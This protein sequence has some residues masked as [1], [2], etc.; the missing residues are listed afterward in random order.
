MTCRSARRR[1]QQQ[2]V[3]AV[4]PQSTYFYFPLLNIFMIVIFIEETTSEYEEQPSTEI[5][6]ETSTIGVDKPKIS[7]PVASDTTTETVHDLDSTQPTADRGRD[8][9]NQEENAV[10]DKVDEKECQYSEFGPWSECT[11]SCGGG[12]QIRVRTIQAGAEFAT[13]RRKMRE[14]RMCNTN[15][16]P[17]I[18]EEDSTTVANELTTTT[19]ELATDATTDITGDK[20]MDDD[21]MATTTITGDDY[22]TANLDN[23]ETQTTEQ[24]LP[25]INDNLQALQ[26]PQGRV[27][28]YSCGSLFSKSLEV[29][30]EFNPDDRGQEVECEE[31]EV[32]LMYSWLSGPSY[33]TVR[34]CFQPDSLLLG[35]AEDPILPSASCD[36]VTIDEITFAC[37]CTTDLC[38]GQTGVE[39]TSISPKTATTTTRQPSTSTR[40]TTTTTIQATTTQK[41]V[42]RSN[43]SRVKCHQCGNLFSNKEA[44]DCDT[45]DAATSV[46]DY[47][48][49]GEACLWYSWGVPGSAPSIIRECLAKV[50]L[51][52]PFE[53]PLL[54]T[55][56][57]EVKDISEEPGT[58]TLACLCESDLCN[59]NA[60][61][62]QLQTQSRSD[63]SSVINNNNNNAVAPVTEN[64]KPV[65]DENTRQV[66]EKASTSIPDPKKQIE[67][68]QCGSLFSEDSSSP[69]CDQFSPR[70]PQQKGL[71]PPG[72]VCILYSFRARGAPGEDIREC[73]SRSTLLGDVNNPLSVESTCQPQLLPGNN[74][75]EVTACLCD[76]DMCNIGTNGQF[77]GEQSSIPQQVQKPAFDKSKYST[78][79]T[80]TS[81]PQQIWETPGTTQRSRPRQPQ[82]P[83]KVRT[84]PRKRVRSDPNRVKCHQCGSLYSG[85]FKIF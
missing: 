44:P 51:L 72:D 74:D 10:P 67:C 36:P 50:I 47:C 80:T 57:C 12:M 11:L 33:S 42:I 81:R 13:C 35:S 9:L 23:N 83:Q 15:K 70:D 8:N 69:E 77:G 3:M 82:K 78:D 24:S 71:C 27:R 63:L 45:F 29:C 7:E 16:C 54:A 65:I 37:T 41:P 61:T 39:T 85:I 55:P 4:S 52:G 28:C 53:D 60:E 46:G 84:K 75:V 62:Q 76:T 26:I 43:P 79:F 48:G 14:G 5:I 19:T 18:P 40:L 58:V 1:G 64:T 68:F 66:T 56:H 31:G 49:E 34:E 17:V 73:I 20:M 25:P 38:N 2:L 30:D 6:H 32:C 21:K 22:V 59:D